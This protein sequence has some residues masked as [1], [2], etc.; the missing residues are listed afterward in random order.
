MNDR[1]VSPPG[2][3]I[4]GDEAA[5]AAVRF[6]FAAQ[7]DSGPVQQIAAEGMLDAPLLHQPQEPRL[8]FLPASLP[9]LV[10]VKK[11]LRGREERLMDVFGAN[12]RDEQ[13]A[14]AVARIFFA[15]QQRDTIPLAARQ[16]ALDSLPELRRCGNLC[17][18]HMPLG[19]VEPGSIR[20]AS[21]LP[22][23]IQVFHSTAGDR[24]MPSLAIE[25]HGGLTISM[26]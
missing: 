16:H 13:P 17:V 15:A 7:K 4:L 9:L 6:R 1:Q 3:Q 20:T 8:V 12:A 25:L 14:V 24:G 22:A 23:Q 11:G 26:G 2:A 21:Q 19:V 5:M 10:I 18:E